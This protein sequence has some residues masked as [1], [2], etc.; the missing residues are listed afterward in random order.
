MQEGDRA[1][2]QAG[3]GPLRGDKGQV[4]EGRKPD[5]G[6]GVGAVGAV[7]QLVQ[8][9][10]HDRLRLRQPEGQPRQRA[11]DQHPLHDPALRR[12]TPGQDA[13]G[14]PAV[15]EEEADGFDRRAAHRRIGVRGVVD[16]VLRPLG[17]LGGDV[18]VR[19][20]L[21]PADRAVDVRR[22][23][24]RALASDA[25]EQ[26]DDLG[27]VRGGGVVRHGEQERQA[28]RR[29]RVDGSMVMGFRV[30]PLERLGPYL[31]GR[32]EHAQEVVRDPADL[33]R[34]VA[35]RPVDIVHVDHERQSA[36]TH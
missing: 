3:G 16:E 35:G 29:A 10:H 11:D 14:T 1:G 23:A 26:P 7:D 24:A 15:R 18:D 6:V 31:W 5:G 8:Q 22:G 30:E 33:P 19:G 32:G 27:P 36:R 4:G 20:R 28:Q 21:D 2:H 17:H 34:Q 13:G 12:Q 25:E 9:G